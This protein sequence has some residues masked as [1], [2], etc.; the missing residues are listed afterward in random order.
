MAFAWKGLAG[1]IAV[2]TTPTMQIS[3]RNTQIFG[4][5]LYALIELSLNRTASGLNALS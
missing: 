4:Y 3:H 1:C 5:G 2:F